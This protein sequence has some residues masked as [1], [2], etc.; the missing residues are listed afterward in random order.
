MGSA[1]PHG[2]AAAAGEIDLVIGT[3]SALF[4]P[5]PNIGLIVVDEEHDQSYKQ[6]STPRYQG[7]D[8][9][10]VYAQQLQVPV[11]L[12]SATPSCE[13]IH[14]VRTGKYTVFAIK[15]TPEW[16]IVTSSSSC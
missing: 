8:L 1:R 15:R 10:I 12:G 5:L 16:F 11:V 9:S 14:N 6:D 4:A 13:S 2:T 3:R 7:R